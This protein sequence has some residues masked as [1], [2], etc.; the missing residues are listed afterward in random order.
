VAYEIQGFDIGTL[1]ASAD[2]SANRY[3]FVTVNS[4]GQVA[5]AA[6]GDPA[7]GVLQNKPAAAGRSAT[8]RVLGVSKV[9]AGAALTK[10][11]QV[12][13]NASGK[14]VTATKAT[15]NT[16]DTGVA[17][18][19]VIASNVLGIALESAAAADEVI[20]VLLLHSGAAPTTEA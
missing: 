19:P 15:V 6:A 4:S 3:Q 13:S 18:D 1:E 11:D 20:S 14:A 16:S 7:I 17:S 12:A 9:K 8:V 5:V 10:G 2:L